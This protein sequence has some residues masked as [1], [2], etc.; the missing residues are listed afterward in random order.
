[1]LPPWKSDVSFLNPVPV[2]L[3]LVRPTL[4]ARISAC[5]LRDPDIARRDTGAVFGLGC[6]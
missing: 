5:M 3:L 2:N 6:S 1:M 4:G